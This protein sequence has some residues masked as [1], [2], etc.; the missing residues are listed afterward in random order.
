M[1]YRRYI[2]L[3]IRPEAPK[4]ITARSPSSRYP[5]VFETSDKYGFDTGTQLP[6]LHEQMTLLISPVGPD[7][8]TRFKL[9]G[10]LTVEV[11]PELVRV[12]AE[13][14][15]QLVLDLTDLQF[16]DRQGVS[17]LRELRAQGAQLIGVSHYLRLLLGETPS[18]GN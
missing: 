2:G 6:H 3:V 9:D 14:K 17:V 12:S 5:W 18:D 8:A 11:V 13:L 4:A 1:Q 15:T 7:P 16:A 10:R